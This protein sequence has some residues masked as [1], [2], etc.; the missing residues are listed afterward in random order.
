MLYIKRNLD[1][2]VSSLDLSKFDSIKDKIESL[3]NKTVS[4]C[5]NFGIVKDKDSLAMA[6]TSLF[7]SKNNNNQLGIIVF[8]WG[9]KSLKKI[10]SIL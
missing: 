4:S 7:G 10:K 2:L 1:S 8:K 3:Q 6:E 5:F 9:A